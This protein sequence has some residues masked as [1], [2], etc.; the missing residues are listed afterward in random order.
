ML[1]LTVLSEYSSI[2]ID[3]D[4]EVH[5]LIRLET[6][7][8]GTSDSSPAVNLALVLDRSGSM[9]GAKLRYTKLAAE[10]LIDR[11]RPRDTLAIVCYD[12]QTDVL[13]QSTPGDEKLVL[14]TALQ[15]LISRGYTNLSSGWLRG[16]SLVAA[17]QKSRPDHVHRV[18]LMTD[19]Q[20]N[21]GIMNPDKLIHLGMKYRQQGISTSTLG[22]GEDFNEDLLTGIAEEAGGHFYYIDNPDKAPSAFVEELG[23][24]SMV[25]GQN[26]EVILQ[27]EAGVQI[28]RNYSHD[29]RQNKNNAVAWRLGDLYANDAKLLLLTVKIPRGYGDKPIAQLG[30]RYHSADEARRH[31][32]EKAI[33][34][35]VTKPG[36]EPGEQ[37]LE[38]VKERLVL[39][40][41][42]AKERAISSVDRGD[43]E[44]ARRS[45]S[46][47]SL[48]IRDSLDDCLDGLS[49]EARQILAVEVKQ[50]EDLVKTFDEGRYSSRTR[51]LMRTQSFH[52]RSQRGVYRRDSSAQI[53]PLA[54]DPE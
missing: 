50:C 43:Y 10:F 23:E 31:H 39:E 8:L 1:K 4:H 40:A 33:L 3:Q 25:V 19:G 28:G 27:C 29:L 11:L 53:R 5:L 12:H 52:S 34:V 21:Q 49:A 42:L 41:A 38:V 14:K 30:V 18:L 2:S 51:K 7:P 24:L 9:E 6:A 35:P 37:N 20:A 13:C 48:I 46:Q 44:T 32:L 26:L 15:Q 47:S 16:L 36:M 54:K 17:M 45:I 22:F